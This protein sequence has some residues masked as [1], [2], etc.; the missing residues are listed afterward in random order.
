LPGLSQPLREAMVQSNGCAIM[1][2]NR[3]DDHRVPSVLADDKLA[4]E[5]AV[6]HLR[7]MGHENIALVAN[8]PEHPV[9]RV[10]IAAWKSCFA[11]EVPASILEHR[12]INVS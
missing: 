5:M 9:V 12:L 11:D 2:G 7:G 6:A 3:F 8:Y 4:M 1:I 10:Q